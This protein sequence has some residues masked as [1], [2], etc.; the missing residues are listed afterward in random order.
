MH[1]HVA[2]MSNTSKLSRFV[3]G[4]DNLTKLKLIHKKR[5]MLTLVDNSTRIEL[6]RS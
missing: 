5:Q 2:H 6:C 1:V 4:L 3:F